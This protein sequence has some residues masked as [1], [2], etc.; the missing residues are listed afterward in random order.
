MVMIHSAYRRSW[1]TLQRR[2][3]D[4]TG[5]EAGHGII[6]LTEDGQVGVVPLLF[7]VFSCFFISVWEPMYRLHPKLLKATHCIL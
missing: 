6:V 4:W 3:M 7:L 1:T 2:G 5:A